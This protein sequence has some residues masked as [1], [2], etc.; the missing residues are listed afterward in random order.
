MGSGQN[1]NIKWEE[2]QSNLQ[3]CSSQLEKTNHF[4]DVTLVGEGGD[5][6]QAH[7]LIMSAT[8]PIFEDILMKSDHPNPLIYMRGI[9]SSHLK[10][11]V[12]YMYQGE[13]EV[14]TE[15]FKD[16]LEMA[17]EL[18]IKGLTTDATSD[19][20]IEKQ[21][22]Q[23]KKQLVYNSL[24]KE[25]VL[26]KSNER[27]E[28]Q[29]LVK[30]EEDSDS[31]YNEETQGQEIWTRPDTKSNVLTKVENT[32]SCNICG[33]SSITKHGLV[34]HKSRYHSTLKIEAAFECK[35]CGRKSISKGGLLQHN[36]RNHSTA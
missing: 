13:V 20:L 27:D 14:S 18:K 36:I 15:D 25:Q 29:P 28:F 21:N 30:Q 12:T 4:S 2:Y 32:Y 5:H 3:L 35:V 33:K 19:T 24:P 23:N 6:I 11:L 9:K 8:S 17:G 26:N 1:Y 16:F 34:K 10:L 31:S 22:I 7:R